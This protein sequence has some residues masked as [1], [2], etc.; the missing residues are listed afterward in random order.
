MKKIVFSIAFLLVTTIAYSQS[1]IIYSKNYEGN[2]VA[3]D[4]YGNVIATKS[5]NYAENYV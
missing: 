5:K 1:R 4:E 3:K 2:T